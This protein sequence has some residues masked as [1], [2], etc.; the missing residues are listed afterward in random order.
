MAAARRPRPHSAHDASHL[1]PSLIRAVLA[2]LAVPLS[3][4]R[5]REEPS[6]GGGVEG[7]SGR[8]RVG[9]VRG[10]LLEL[11]EVD[12]QLLD[13]VRHSGTMRGLL[14]ACVWHHATSRYRF[15]RL[16]GNAIAPTEVRAGSFPT[17]L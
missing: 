8:G 10:L 4:R 12:V 16:C 7:W 15:D 14:L 1:V 9:R 17:R 5:C 11:L 3:C 6:R 13:G 2:L